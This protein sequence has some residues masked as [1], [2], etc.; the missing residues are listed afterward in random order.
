MRFTAAGLLVLAGLLASCSA[1]HVRPGTQSRAGAQSQGGT[2]PAGAQA[3]AHAQGT[4]GARLQISRGPWWSSQDEITPCGPPALV[5]AAGHV[6]GVGT[7]GQGFSKPPQKVTLIVG[8]R[9]DVHVFEGAVPHSSRP[10]VLAPGAV[11]RDRTTQTYRAASPGHAVLVSDAVRCFVI[12][13]PEL[14]R[15]TRTCPVIAVTVVP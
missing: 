15:V 12:S 4:A 11:S 6:M 8:Q 14:N 7:C 2:R 3:S 10:S 9:I 5:R 1:A 13:H